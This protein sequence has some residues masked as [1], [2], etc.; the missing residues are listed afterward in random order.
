MKSASDKQR[1]D[2][3]RF[4]N[5]NPPPVPGQELDRIRHLHEVADAFF[6]AQQKRHTADYDNSTQWTRTDVL[7]LI[8]LVESAFTS[9]HAIRDAPVAQ[10]FLISLLAR[11]QG[12][13]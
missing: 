5:S 7:T 11:P 1:A 2:C 8:A 13:A 6:Q 10:V 4:I 9:W 12:G 3:K